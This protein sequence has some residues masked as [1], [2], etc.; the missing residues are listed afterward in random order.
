[1]SDDKIP[2]AFSIARSDS[3]GG[4]GIQPDIHVFS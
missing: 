4:T 2:V 1:M 3:R